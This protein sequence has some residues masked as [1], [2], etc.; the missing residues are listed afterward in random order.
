MTNIFP[1]PQNF[2]LVNDGGYATPEFK[3]YMDDLLARSGGI[4]GGSYQQLTDAPTVTW[5]L[6]LKPVA[7]VVLGGNRTLADPTGT[8]AGNFTP[9]RLTVIQDATGGRTLTW[10]GAYRFAGGTPPTLSTA[11]NAVDEFWFSSDG[12]NMKLVAGALDLR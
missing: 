11:A 1:V 8:V 12:T 5:P 7:V 2:R 3:R 9:Y 10:G 6:D 4:P